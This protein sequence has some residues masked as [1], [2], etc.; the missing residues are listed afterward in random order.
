MIFTNSLKYFNMKQSFINCY[1]MNFRI[2]SFFLIM[3]NKFIQ[4]FRHKIEFH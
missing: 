3:N 4:V 2:V 1:K